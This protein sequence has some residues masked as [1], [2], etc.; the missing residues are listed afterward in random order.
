MSSLVRDKHLLD[1]LEQIE[2]K[3]FVGTVWRS[4]RQKRPAGECG[5]AGGRWDDREFDVLYTSAS[6]EGAIEERRFHLFRGQPFPPSK[7][8]YDLFQIEIRLNSAITFP[9]L[10][11][12]Q[13][14][15]MNT[16]RFGASSYVDREGEYPRS[17]EV[18]EACFFLGADAIV[19]P[20]A[21]HDSL[22][23]IV[24]CDQDPRPTIGDPKFHSV[25]QW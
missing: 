22:N 19:V 13:E 2:P 16:N 9:D 6:Q 14:V 8:L 24:F 17:Q 11:A 10:D 1:S 20:C 3:P 4:V 21:R 25:I 23:V 5:R 15:G 12:L 7:V 18:A